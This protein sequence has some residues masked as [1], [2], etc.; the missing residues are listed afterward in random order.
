MMFFQNAF[1]N[2]D[3][4]LYENEYL[5]SQITENEVI[6]AIKNLKSGKSPGKDGLN[7]P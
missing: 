3:D 1:N 6:Q 7:K 5:D 4:R 2:Q